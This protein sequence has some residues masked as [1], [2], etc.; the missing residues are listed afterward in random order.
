MVVTCPTKCGGP[1]PVLK[2]HDFVVEDDAIIATRL[3]Q[4]PNKRS[5]YHDKSRAESLLDKTFTIK[6]P[7]KLSSDEKCFDFKVL[8]LI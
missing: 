7:L 3:L 6:T 2:P 4:S 1:A 8:N 5:S